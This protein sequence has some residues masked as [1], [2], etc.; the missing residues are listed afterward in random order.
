MAPESD[1]QG[2][3]DQFS[4]QPLTIQVTNSDLVAARYETVLFSAGSNGCLIASNTTVTL[5]TTLQMD[6]NAQGEATVYAKLPNIYPWTDNIFATV[7]ETTESFSVATAIPDADC[8]PDGD[9][10]TNSEEF[11]LGTDQLDYYNGIPPVLA[12][13]GGNQQFVQPNTIA[14]DPLVIQV[15][16]ANGQ[17]LVN[18]PVTFTVTSGGGML[19]RA[20]DR[21]PVGHGVITDQ[22]D[23]EGNV[24]VFFIAPSNPG[25]TTTVVASAQPYGQTPQP[26]FTETSMSTVATPTVSPDGAANLTNNINVT[27]ACGTTDA[28]IHYSLSGFEPTEDDQIVASGDTVTIEPGTT[29]AVKAFKANMNP[30]DTKSATYGGTDN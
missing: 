23:S 8:D 1:V 16:T 15:K 27:V 14:N 3:P 24:S 12:V 10:L 13:T 18:A 26:T 19:A 29:L 17:S 11:V 21:D 25:E 30:S 6:A 28:V 4:E 9:G 5:L 22:T 7:Y 2:F 20:S